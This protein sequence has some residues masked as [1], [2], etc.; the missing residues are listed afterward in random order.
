MHER[1]TLLVQ[2]G[3]S[4]P[5]LLKLGDP[6]RNGIEFLLE[7][8]DPLRFANVYALKDAIRIVNTRGLP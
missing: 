3:V 5:L 6:C 4:L 8:L 1:L 7:R 2:F